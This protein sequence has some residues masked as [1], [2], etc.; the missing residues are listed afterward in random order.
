MRDLAD[1]DL[2]ERIQAWSGCP[3]VCTEFNVEELV[4][5]SFWFCRHSPRPEWA[6]A[7][8]GVLAHRHK[9]LN[10]GGGGEEG[11]ERRREEGREESW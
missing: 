4:F 7:G 1:R 11:R 3:A 9:G 8:G 10:G 5:F 6:A 2:E